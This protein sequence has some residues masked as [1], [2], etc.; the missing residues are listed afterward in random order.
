[1]EEAKRLLWLSSLIK[2][3]SKQFVTNLRIVSIKSWHLKVS[4]M[5][6]KYWSEVLLRTMSWEMI[7][8]YILSIRKL[9]WNVTQRACR[10]QFLASLESISLAAASKKIK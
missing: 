3:S 6:H 2:L 5:K 8:G 4:R 1:M 10:Q 7:Q 9:L